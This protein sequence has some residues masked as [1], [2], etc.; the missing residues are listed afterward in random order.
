MVGTI[1]IHSFQEPTTPIENYFITGMKLEAVNKQNPA[2][3]SVATVAD[4]DEERIRIEFDS[5]KGSGYWC[6]YSDRD[7]FPAGWCSRS[8]HPLKPPGKCLFLLYSEICIC[9]FHKILAKKN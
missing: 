3:I 4:T 8:G 2:I 7:L 6:H 9:R 1:L 5:Y